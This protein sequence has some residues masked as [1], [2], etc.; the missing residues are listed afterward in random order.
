MFESGKVSDLN[1]TYFW[2]F[3]LGLASIRIF[4]VLHKYVLENKWLQKC[5]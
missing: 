1:Q 3:Y 4:A 2:G 5:I